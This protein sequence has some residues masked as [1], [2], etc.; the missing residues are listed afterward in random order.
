MAPRHHASSCFLINPPSFPGFCNQHCPCRDARECCLECCGG[1]AHCLPASSPVPSKLGSP[2]SGQKNDSI[3]FKVVS[4]P[5]ALG[6]QQQRQETSLLSWRGRSAGR[7]QTTEHKT[8]SRVGSGKDGGERWRGKGV[9]KEGDALLEVVRI[10]S[11][12]RG[13]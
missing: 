7:S 11:Q 1:V 5:A 9:G 10:A 2:L 12:I 3:L 13:I 6:R 8:Y 4:F